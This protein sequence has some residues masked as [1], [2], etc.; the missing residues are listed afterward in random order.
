[1]AVNFNEAADDAFKY[2]TLLTEALPG[3][4][5]RPRHCFLRTRQNLH[6]SFD[7]HKPFEVLI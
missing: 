4:S 2:P 1:M 5:V 3:G 6:D 7:E